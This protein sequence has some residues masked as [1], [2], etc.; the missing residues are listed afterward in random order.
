MSYNNLQDALTAIDVGSWAT[1][2]DVWWTA[3]DGESPKWT[4]VSV[5][6]YGRLRYEY[7]WYTQKGDWHGYTELVALAKAMNAASKALNESLT[8]SAKA[9]V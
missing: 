8:A 2:D 9:G 1:E 5:G 7:G 4:V 3:D 6:E